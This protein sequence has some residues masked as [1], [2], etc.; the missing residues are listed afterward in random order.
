MTK[1]TEVKGGQCT[2]P[3]ESQ[4]E[5]WMSSKRIL[6]LCA[7]HNLYSADAGEE[8]GKKANVDEPSRL[9]VN[10]DDYYDYEID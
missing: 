9:R 7:H 8:M 10:T 2:S 6:D 3:M 4:G 5:S 1:G